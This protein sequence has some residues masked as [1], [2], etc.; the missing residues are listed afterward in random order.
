MTSNFTKFHG[1]A[2]ITGNSIEMMLEVTNIPQEKALHKFLRFDMGSSQ[3]NKV[4]H[5]WAIIL[6]ISSPFVLLGMLVLIVW[7]LNLIL[8]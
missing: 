3:T 6:G 7:V 1:E 4:N 5:T 8:K 2:E